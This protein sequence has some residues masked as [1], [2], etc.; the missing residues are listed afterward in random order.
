MHH[1]LTCACGNDNAAVIV[2][3][4]DSA[5][6]LGVVTGNGDGSADDG[7]QLTPVGLVCSGVVLELLVDVIKGI[8]L[9]DEDIGAA[10][11]LGGPLVDGATRAGQINGIAVVLGVGIDVDAPADADGIDVVRHDT[12][13]AQHAGQ[14]AALGAIHD[15]D[16]V[17]PF[18]VHRS[19]GDVGNGLREHRHKGIDDA[20]G[21]RG[22]DVWRAE[23][24]R[25]E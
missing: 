2:E 22:G 14:F 13:F 17:R 9:G 15:D 3:L 24:E 11:G 6:E 23:Q 25:A 12:C 10:D 8:E 5:T 16:V 1:V 18:D 7:H 4:R 21:M 19:G 20:G